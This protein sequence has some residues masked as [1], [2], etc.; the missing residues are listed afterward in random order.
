[1]VKNGLSEFKGDNG[2]EIAC[3]NI[4]SQALSTYL[5]GPIWV[6]CRL[7]SAAFPGSG[8][9]RQPSLRNWLDPPPAWRRLIQWLFGL[10]R[11]KNQ[12]RHP[13][14]RANTIAAHNE[15]QMA[16]LSGGN[17]GW[18]TGNGSNKWFVICPKLKSSTFTKMAEMFDCCLSGQ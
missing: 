17:G 1:M 18:N 13:L 14:N 4:Y 12:K 9:A 11:T 6:M 16:L 3:G 15:R 10:G 7:A 2:A 5:A 8:F